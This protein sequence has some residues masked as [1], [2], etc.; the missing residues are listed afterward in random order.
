MPKGR[1]KTHIA[2]LRSLL[3]NGKPLAIDVR[4]LGV[5]DQALD[6][7]DLSAMRAA[8]SFGG[9]DV[10]TTVSIVNGVAV[11]PIT[12]VLRDQVDFMVRWA[13]SACYQLIEKDLRQALGN[14]AVKAVLLYFDTPGGS[15]IGVKRA[16]DLIFASRG[17][18][19]IVAYV[20]GICG[21]AGY[22]LAS[23]CDRIESTA[24][25]LVG[26]IGT[27]LPH[28]EGS[29]MFDEWGLKYTVITN[30]DS[31]K[32]GHGNSYEPLSDAAKQS[33]QA[34]VESYGRSF[35]EDV[36][37]YREVEVDE[38]IAKYGQGDA[39]RAD[40][41]IGAGMIDKVVANFQETLSALTSDSDNSPTQTTEQ[42]TTPVVTGQIFP[43]QENGKM[44]ER[45]IAQLYALD[46]IDSLKPS[47]AAYNAALRAYF[48][49]ANMAL[50]QDDAA[51]LQ[52]LQTPRAGDSASDEE[53]IEEEEEEVAAE[54]RT[55][56]RQPANGKGK[57]KPQNNVQEAHNQEQ[58]EA[59]LADLRAAAELVN[60]AAG[61][62]A[63]TSAMVLDA[64]QDEKKLDAR[65]AMAKWNKTLA[66]NEKTVPSYRVKGEGADHFAADA[67]DALLYRT[68]ENKRDMQLSEG[69]EALVNRPL[70]AIAAQCLQ[71]A[72]N[73]DVDPYNTAGNE[74]L[75][76]CAM[77]MGGVGERHTFYSSQENKQYIQ[78]SG[79]PYNRPGDFPNILS[80][81][82]NK[83]L[84][85][86]E[87]DEDYSYP[88]ISAMLPG[89]LNDFK[90]AL[91]INKGVVEELDEVE[92]AEGFKELGMKEEVLSYLFL[93]RFGNKFG[94]TPLMIANDDLGAFVEGMIGLAQAWQVTQNRLVIDLISSNPT[95]LDGT[96]LFANRAD[97][98]GAANNNLRG[99]GSSP[100]DAEWEAMEVL[101]SDIGGIGTQRRVRGTLNTIFCPTGTVSHEAHRYF[102]PLN[103]VG[104]IKQ[105]ATSA[106]L[107]L[108]RGK[109][110]IVP[111]SELRNT[112]AIE[113]YGLR[114]PTKLN[115]ATV[116]RAYFNGFGAMG[117]RE[118]WYDPDRKVTWVSLEGR[119]ATAIKNWRYAVKNAGTGA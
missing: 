72:G 94:W 99:T 3:H 77:R 100:S 74:A 39:M 15:A 31:P 101:Y 90:P 58:G 88:L 60:E 78:A 19:P 61:Y 85:T 80:G 105:A 7:G 84:D 4:A 28:V 83:F 46:L 65:A 64:F 35:I 102:A 59:R 103:I 21:S 47:D 8:L 66:E 11:I 108:F 91:M 1:Q 33:L 86:I 81:L 111:E 24:D 54:S 38:V 50:P 75:A 51:I 87:L 116:V 40:I 82:S 115:T 96:A 73:R 36:A 12:G 79:S 37:R 97:V 55:S 43:K 110:N 112:S 95:L 20:Q 92:D 34:F 41:A 10:E 69:A 42:T 27:I 18:K 70:H 118:R 29:K 2:R 53:E 114:S 106:N 71:L 17:D 113:W 119:I 56:R 93:R 9:G 57:G 104:E 107:G 63:V 30:T 16:A 117:R 5:I 67:I 109:V 26:S 49:G 6:S 14:A 32:K 68:V 76:D 44:K 52:A 89:G 48:R 62:E 13:G 25:S 98:G 23:A 45:I 22:Y